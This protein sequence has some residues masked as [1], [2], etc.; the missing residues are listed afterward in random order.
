MNITSLQV[1]TDNGEKQLSGSGLQLTGSRTQPY[2]SETHSHLE[3]GASQGS[4]REEEVRPQMSYWKKMI[5]MQKSI[6]VI[7]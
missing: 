4:E 2:G 7:K 5:T 6:I 1:D 3:V